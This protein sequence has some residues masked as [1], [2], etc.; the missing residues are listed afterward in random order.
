MAEFKKIRGI[1]IGVQEIRSNN[2]PLV[3]VI[4]PGESD[5]LR[6]IIIAALGMALQAGEPVEG[7][8]TLRMG[9]QVGA[10]YDDNVIIVATPVERLIWCAKQY[11]GVTSEPTL[12]SQNKAFAKLSRKQRE[13]NAVTI[14]GDVDRVFPLIREDIP[15]DQ[16]RLIESIGDIGN[17]DEITTSLSLEKDGLAVETNIGFKDGHSCLAYDLI[18]TPN[19]TRAGFEAVPAEA[20]ALVSFALGEAEGTGAASARKAVK[21][22]TGLDIGR[23]LFANIEQITLFALPPSPT[24]AKNILAESISPV[25][26]CLGLAVTSRNPRRTEQLVT[27]WLT[28]TDLLMGISKGEELVEQRSPAVGEYKIGEFNGKPAYCYVGQAGKSTVLTLSPEVLQASLSAVESK[29]SAS[30]AGPLHGVLSQ[31]L[32]GTSKLAAVNAAGAIQLANVHICASRGISPDPQKNYLSQLLSEYAQACTETYVVVR[33]DEKANNFGLNVNV[34]GLPDFGRVFPLVAQ[35]PAAMENPMLAATEPRPADRAMVKPAKAVELNW[36]PGG[37]AT[38]HKVYFGTSIDNL[39]LLAE[40]SRPSCDK[41]PASERGVTYYWRVDG[42]R[43]DG[44]IITGDIWQFSP[45]NLVGWWKLDNDAKDSSGN[46]HHGTL[47]GDPKWVTGK[48]GGALEFDGDDAVSL[49]GSVGTGSLLNIHKSD[50]TVS[51]WVKIRGKGGTIVARSKPL[52]IAY[53]LGVRTNKAYINTYKQGPG[54]WTLYADEIL[55]PETWYH[56]VGVFDRVGDRGR[57][58]VNGVEKA[59]GIMSTDPLSNDA[60]TKIGCRND[61]GDSA[62]EGTIDDVRI[63]NYALSQEEILEICPPTAAT[64]PQPADKGLVK[65]GAAVQLSWTPGKDAT[66]H[67]IYFG[68]NADELPRLAQVKTPG[69]STPQALQRG[70]TY[71]W[72]VDEVQAHGAVV[73]GDIWRFSTGKL[74][75][76]W[77]FDETSGGTAADSS[78]NNYHGTR[79]HGNPVWSPDGKFGGC[80]YFNEMYGFAIPKEVFDGI[81]KAITISVWVNGDEDQEPHSNVILQAGAGRGGRPYIVTVK[82]DWKK[83]G[84]VAF[85]TGRGEAEQLSYIARLDEWAGRWSHYAFVKDADEGFM[86]IYVNGRLVD[87]KSGTTASMAGVGAARIGIAPDRF[88]DQY[89]GKL[90]DLRIYN[91]ALSAEEIQQLRAVGAGVG[92]PVEPIEPGPPAPHEGPSYLEGLVGHWKFDEGVIPSTGYIYRE[93]LEIALS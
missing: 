22:L 75:A 47:K 42:V 39:P 35:I 32:P 49:E 80:L 84:Q 17:V 93:A 23:E 13:Q 33:T 66:A 16:R 38:A 89:V 56:I 21:K 14:W 4:Y 63:Y 26:L 15:E 78:G 34:S 30:S 76:W 71:F 46:N 70:V 7:M 45:G 91:Y 28:L 86:R 64:K 24:S 6:G 31:L 43:A 55:E 10:A 2:P 41:L 68:T 9:Q 67:R 65:P 60:S 82:T 59:E 54:H 87:E 77:K 19:I 69:Y 36:E 88:G 50:L 85:M 8:Q 3:A 44:S 51:S 61:T 52:H 83:D 20:V 18:R 48:I 53:T 79:V 90:D 62:F 74:V 92:P 5:A 57:V 27:Q 1:A 73:T 72:R 81:D 37:G 58:Y 11:K 12:L 40:V 25:V 29:T